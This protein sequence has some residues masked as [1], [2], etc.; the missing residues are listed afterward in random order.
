MVLTLISLTVSIIFCNGD[1][2]CRENEGVRGSRRD[3]ILAQ[4]RGWCPLG[5]PR[6]RRRLAL[7][8]TMVWRSRGRDEKV[9]NEQASSWKDLQVLRPFPRHPA[10]GFR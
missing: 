5:L 1:V 4:R 2:L 10:A 7:K 9:G 6:K 3:G 8:E